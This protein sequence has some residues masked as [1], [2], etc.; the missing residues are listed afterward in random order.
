MCIR[1][2]LGSIPEKVLPATEIE[3]QARDGSIVPGVIGVKA[4]HVTPPEEK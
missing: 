4:H 1:D 3:I 2:R